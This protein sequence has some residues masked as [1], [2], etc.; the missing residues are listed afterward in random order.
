MNNANKFTT[1]ITHR[2]REKASQGKANES[3]RLHAKTY[4]FM[5]MSAVE[6]EKNP[7]RDV[8]IHERVNATN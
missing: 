2:L 5:I 6:K 7:A 4:T 1:F 8:Q 3:D